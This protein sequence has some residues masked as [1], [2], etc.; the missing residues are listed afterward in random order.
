MLSFQASKTFK[1][2]KSFNLSTSFPLQLSLRQTKSLLSHKDSSDR[3]TK[4]NKVDLWE[5]KVTEFQYCIQCTRFIEKFF[6][7]W[8]NDNDIES[9]FS[10][11]HFEMKGIL[12]AD[13][14]SNYNLIRV[15]QNCSTF[16]ALYTLIP[17][18]SYQGSTYIVEKDSI[19]KFISYRPQ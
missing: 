2:A 16:G 8:K 4:L 6:W 17:K 9:S 14:I 11:F 13:A 12:L 1:K 15:T 5:I 10:R 18:Q 3:E 19:Q 7:R